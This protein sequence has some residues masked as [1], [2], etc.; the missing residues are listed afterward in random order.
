MTMAK[1]VTSLSAIDNTAP[2]TDLRPWKSFVDMKDE[3]K[4]VEVHK[5]KSQ[6]NDM[7]AK[8]GK[9]IGIENLSLQHLM[10]M[11]ETFNRKVTI[12]WNPKK[13][14]WFRYVEGKDVPSWLAGLGKSY[15]D[16]IYDP[17][18]KTPAGR[19]VTPEMIAQYR[20]RG[21]SSSKATSLEDL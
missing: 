6:I 17:S 19:N 16:Y 13:N 7:I 5:I 1:T 20:G 10:T 18:G 2:S 9:E 14:E 4:L 15:K 11:P 8:L 21:S 12:V 3:D